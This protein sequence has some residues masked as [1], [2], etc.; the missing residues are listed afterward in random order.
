MVVCVC[1]CV[2]YELN[3]FIKKQR[4]I[5][6]KVYIYNSIFCCLFYFS[7]VPD[8]SS[9]GPGWCCIAASE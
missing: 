1:V 6:K 5:V 9:E 7:S 2:L 8:H 4:E 3:N